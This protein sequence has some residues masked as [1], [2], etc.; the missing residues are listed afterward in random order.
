MPQVERI[1]FDN[2]RFHQKRERMQQMQKWYADYI[3]LI[4]DGIVFGQICVLFQGANQNKAWL[5]AVISGK[6]Q[7]EVLSIAGTDDTPTVVLDKGNGV[8][9][10]TGRSLPEDTVGFYEPVVA[11][12]SAYAKE[13]AATT[14]FTFKLDYFNTSS[15]KMIL[16]LLKQLKAISGMKIQWYY[17]DDD[18]E[19]LEAGKEYAEQVDVPFEFI[20]Y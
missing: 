11:W 19:I 3:N 4:S 6:R 14:A 15:S 12:I 9:K 7:M 10:I 16:D 8:F 20:P 18:E 1:E 13:P 5:V 2:V 17:Q